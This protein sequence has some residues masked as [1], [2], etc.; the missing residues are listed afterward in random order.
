[1]TTRGWLAVPMLLAI[2]GCG[3][4]AGVDPRQADELPESADDTAAQPAP[5]TEGV[6]RPLDAEIRWTSYGIPHVKASDRASLGYGFAYA[7]ARN[8]VCVIARELVMVN[9]EL[10]RYFGRSDGNRA[11]DVFHKVVLDEARIAAFEGGETAAAAAFSRGYV[12]GY[13]RYLREHRQSLP[14]SCANAEWLRPMTRDDV[15]RLTI[16]VGIRYGLGRYQ[17]EMANAAPPGRRLSARS[18]VTDFEAPEAYGSNAVA[19]GRAVTETGHGMLLGNPHYPWHGSSRFHLIH[20]TIPGELDV[21]GVSLYNTSRVGI[22]FNNDVAW[23]HTV[24]TATRATLYELSLHPRN[25]LRYRYGSGYRDMEPVT[26]EVGHIGTDGSLVTEPHRVYMTHYGPVIRSEQLPWTRSTAYAVRDANLHN[27]RAAVTYDALHKATS[28]DEV[29]AAISQQGV[30]WTNT[31]AADRHGTAFYADISVT[32][33]IDAVLLYTCR[34][35]LAGVPDRVV[36]LDGSDPDCEWHQDDRSAVPGALPAEDMPR[37]KRDDYVANSNDSYWIPNPDHPLE[38]Y[39]PIIGGERT[40]L[41]LRTRAGFAF[42]REHLAI[43]GNF[44]PD[45]LQRM[46]YSQRNYAA[47]LLLDDLLRLCA[48]APEPVDL[49]GRAVDVAPA[50][51]ALAGWDRRMTN[52][53]RGGHVWQEFWREARNYDYLFV[54]PFVVSDPLATPRQL[55][56]A[57]E[58]VSEV[59]LRALAQAQVR[60]LELDIPLDAELG[61]IQYV[62][63]NGD[64]LPIPGGE[65][66]A[67]MWSMIVSELTPAGYTPIISGNSYIQVISWDDDGQLDARGMLTYSQSPEPD[68][69]H[70]ADLTRL[71]SSGQWIPLPFTD[72]QIEADPNLETLRLQE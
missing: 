40:A 51:A 26:V 17:N 31:I 27:D 5:A 30:P 43:N 10:S 18:V 24:S 7:T 70:Y 14:A 28:V 19:L 69:P 2:A 11:S 16:S 1:M 22:G 53:S 15:T 44:S 64:R 21:M 20:T 63:V 54:I 13:N 52:A 25:P 9:G 67:G 65:G 48:Q 47:E 62:D 49:D 12:A 41:S 6:Q 55:A 72:A 57:D 37:L 60:L 4:G 50:C 61:D 66:W 58:E 45:D 36:V 33:N 46:L 23:T 8:A 38:G 68:S 3:N 39:S 34:V 35:E 71:Y 59:L 42:I 32:P 29:E 56:V